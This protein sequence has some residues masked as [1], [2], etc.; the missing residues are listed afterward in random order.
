MSPADHSPREVTTPERAAPPDRVMTPPA[1]LAG[2]M[3]L[4]EWSEEDDIS[5][6]AI[7]TTLLHRWRMI[8]AFMLAGGSL[9]LATVV[10]NPALYKA[11]ASFLPRNTDNSTSQLA[12]LAGQLGLTLPSGN[13]TLSPDFYVTLLTSR[14]VLLPIARDTFAVS[15]KGI[16]RQSFYEIFGIKQDNRAVADEQAITTLRHLISVSIVKSTGVVEFS[17]TTKWPSVSL[18]IVSKLLAGI[19]HYNGRA[20]QSQASAERKFVEGRLQIATDQLRN[21]ENRLQEFLT[22]NRQWAGSTDLTFTRERLQRDVNLKQQ[23][24]TSLA[25]AFEEAKIREVRD[26]PVIS[27]FEVPWVPAV[28]E[29]RGRLRRSMLGVMIGALIGVLTTL[30]LGAIAR[31]RE[32]GKTDIIEFLTALNAVKRATL[33]R[34]VSRSAR[35]GG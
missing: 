5:L 22:T 31:R 1:K 27:V 26:M 4:P 18:A 8:I 15:E 17:A 20:L 14:V 12:G 11:S 6:F 24:Y 25:Q 16:R 13:P 10:T 28:A 33:G 19:N 35:P 23:I 29:P 34:F 2:R 7:A 32:Q 3:S 21:S 30:V 9:A